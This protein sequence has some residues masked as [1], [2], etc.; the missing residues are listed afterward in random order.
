MGAPRDTGTIGH[1]S[2]GVTGPTGDEVSKIARR[3]AAARTEGSEPYRRRRAEI[4]AA[5]ARVFKRRGF[6][7][8]TVSHIAEELGTDRASLYYYVSSKEEVFEEIVDDAVR[9]CVERATEI[10]DR[11]DSGAARLRAL[12]QELMSAYEEF[13]PV[14]YVLLQENLNHVA[15]ERGA[16]AQSMRQPIRDWEAIL[17]EIVTAGQR[18]GTIAIVGEPA[19]VAL[20]VTGMVSWS[21]R[22]FNPS[23]S[24]RTGQELGEVF[25][26]MLLDG[27]ETGP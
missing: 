6:Q 2:D 23:R 21:Y 10:R 7:G 8:T 9:V 1:A 3:R 4:V 25:S 26:A 11:P 18:D 20:G 27:L 12:V 13:Y 19:V 17:V 5:A 24:A 16:W 22:W 15:A 14:L